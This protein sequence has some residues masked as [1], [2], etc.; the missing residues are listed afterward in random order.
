MSDIKS[1]K[2]KNKEYNSIGIKEHMHLQNKFSEYYE[3]QHTLSR[4]RYKDGLGAGSRSASSASETK[5]GERSSKLP[6]GAE[7]HFAPEPSHSPE[8]LRYSNDAS[9]PVQSPE[10]VHNKNDGQFSGMSVNQTN[11][12]DKA[13][14]SSL[15]QRNMQARK[16]QQINMTAGN[17]ATR[18]STIAITEN[19]YN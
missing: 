7:A 9:L 11:A 2:K 4:T 15:S 10:Q 19:R 6:G 13:F 3:R 12:S 17:S 5:T 1:I 16:S 8:S 14:S 18:L